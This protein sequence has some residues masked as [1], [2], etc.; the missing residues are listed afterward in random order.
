MNTGF[1]RLNLTHH[2]IKLKWGLFKN[3]EIP[4][5]M[6]FHGQ[7]KKKK[8]KREKKNFFSVFFPF[9]AKFHLNKSNQ[10]ILLIYREVYLKIDNLQ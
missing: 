8:K 6:N 4:I 9:P 7:K 3:K 2:L 5:K 1:A 10:I